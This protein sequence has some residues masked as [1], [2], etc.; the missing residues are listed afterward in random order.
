M[1]V[2]CKL[3][4]LLWNISVQAKIP[5]KGYVCPRCTRKEGVINASETTTTS[6]KINSCH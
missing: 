5:K 4:N 6:R 3:C 2:K 1:K